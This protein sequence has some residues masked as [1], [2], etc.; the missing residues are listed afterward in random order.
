[1]MAGPL[2]QSERCTLDSRAPGRSGG[3][4]EQEQRQEQENGLQ[5]Q[6]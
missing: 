5:E 4:G 6:A 3:M 2:D 1:M